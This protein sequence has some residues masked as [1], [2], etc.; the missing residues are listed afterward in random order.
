MSCDPLSGR[1]WSL[2]PCIPYRYSAISFRIFGKD[3]CSASGDRFI[4]EQKKSKAERAAIAAAAGETAAQD[5]DAELEETGLAPI[6]PDSDDD[7][8]AANA[9]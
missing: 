3:L 4:A 8:A 2:I 9:A 6:A 1:H 5:G 7:D